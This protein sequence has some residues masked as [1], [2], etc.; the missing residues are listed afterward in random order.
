MS[1]AFNVSLLKDLKAGKGCEKEAAAS[2]EWLEAE[3]NRL[4]A[5]C[6]DGERAKARCVELL[7]INAELLAACDRLA[8]QCRILLNTS[9]IFSEADRWEAKMD[10]DAGEAAI[11]EAAIANSKSLRDD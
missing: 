5:I 10:I 8:K 3:I 11:G 4:N 7:D 2:I 6:E 9:A 1:K